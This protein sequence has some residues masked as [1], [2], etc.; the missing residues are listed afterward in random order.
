MGLGE[1]EGGWRPCKQCF[2]FIHVLPSFQPEPVNALSVRR[3][4]KLHICKKVKTIDGHEIREI[5]H[6]VVY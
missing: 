4:G 2:F 3:T 6:T 5:E 1:G